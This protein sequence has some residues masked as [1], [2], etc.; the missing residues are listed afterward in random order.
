MYRVWVLVFV[1]LAVIAQAQTLARVRA[2]SSRLK[3]EGLEG[4]HTLELHQALRDWIEPQLPPSSAALDQTFAQLSSRLEEG[5]RRSDLLQPEGE[6]T[7]FGR[8]SRLELHRAQDTAE[9][10]VVI[11]GVAVPCGSHDAV[12]VYDYTLGS[13]RRVLESHGTREHDQT[14]EG[15]RISRTNGARQVILTL[16]TPVQCA[17]AWSTLAY[18]VFDLP[19][20]SN[21]STPVL[22]EEHGIWFGPDPAYQIRLEP[23]E[24]FVELRSSSIDGGIHN[25]AHVLHYRAPDWSNR[26]DPVALQPQDFVDEWL[27]RPWTEM[28]SRSAPGRRLEEWRA[29]L[30]EYGSIST[31]QDCREHPGQWLVAIEFHRLD[32]KELAEPRTVYFLVRQMEQYRFRMLDVSFERLSGCPGDAGPNLGIPSLFSTPEAEQK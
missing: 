6:P 31:V 2:E 19:S 24:F 10:L 26:L 4:W 27:T 32:G 29:I 22:S 15:V 17:S 30:P 1:G 28:E 8:V 3:G 18:D 11:V 14:V 9:K 5:L 13:P 16:R 25:R 7:R 12:Y 20:A 21:R 23:D